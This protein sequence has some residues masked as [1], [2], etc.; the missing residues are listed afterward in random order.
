MALGSR[1]R[2]LRVQLHM[3]QRQLAGKDLTREYVSMIE[4]DRVIPSRHTLQIL[5]TRLG[6]SVDLLLQDTEP[7]DALDKAASAL[8]HAADLAEAKQYDEALAVLAHLLD[9]TSHEYLVA[10]SGQLQIT[11]LSQLGRR[12][13]AVAAAERLWQRLERSDDDKTLIGLVSQLGRLYFAQD[14]FA[15]ARGAYERL[16]Q[17]TAYK[18]TAAESHMLGLMYLGTCNLRLGALT[19]A[20]KRYQEAFMVGSEQGLTSYKGDAARG[21][22]K[23]LFQLGNQT[24]SLHWTLL[25]C[26]IYEQIGSESLVFAMHNLAVVQAAMGEDDEAFRIYRECLAVYRRQNRL[27]LQASILEELASCWLARGDHI[28][29]RECCREALDLLD[30]ADDG[31]LRL[32]VYRVLGQVERAGGDLGIAYEMLRMSYNLARR[33]RADEEAARTRDVMEQVTSLAPGGR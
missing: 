29:A 19:A 6:T 33:L 9:N 11:C 12:D 2:S 16:V 21:I 18:K 27:D 14:D 26:Q 15:R 7:D 23:A 28:R 13:E 31:I 25:A 3:S 30:L 17:L 4:N 32:R 8:A 20:V 5:A 22:G 1:A 10:Q 24:E